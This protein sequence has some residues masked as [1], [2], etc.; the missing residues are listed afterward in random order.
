M[1]R[2]LM[3]LPALLKALKIIQNELNNV[4]VNILYT[5]VKSIAY[6]RLNRD[7]S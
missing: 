2:Y 3:E 1:R 6:I 4:N 5:P 7:Y